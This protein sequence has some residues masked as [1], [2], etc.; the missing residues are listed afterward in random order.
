MVDSEWR[1]RAAGLVRLQLSVPG[2]DLPDG[3]GLPFT[4]VTTLSSPG[5]AWPWAWPLPSEQAT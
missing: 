4:W 5:P 3:P 1:R 2:P